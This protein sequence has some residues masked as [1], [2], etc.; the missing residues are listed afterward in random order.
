MAATCWLS[1]RWL[2][3]FLASGTS[4]GNAGVLAAGGIPVT[5]PDF[6]KKPFMLFDRTA[7][8]FEMAL[9]AEAAAFPVQLFKNT[10]EDVKTYAKGMLPLIYDAVDQ[11]KTLAN[12]TPAEAFIK[13]VD[14][15]FG[16]DTETRYLTTCPVG[17]RKQLG[18]ELQ[19]QSGEEYTNRS[20]L[21]R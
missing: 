16:Y 2:I 19:V 1:V 17:L 20:P 4:F 10:E 15:C 7:L 5:T 12:G 3:R 13:D 6:G 21:C 14:Y 8:I 9:S 18:F 11:H